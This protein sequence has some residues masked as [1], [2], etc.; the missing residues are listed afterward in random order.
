MDGRLQSLN[1]RIVREMDA[2]L[3][4]SIKSVI[5]VILGKVRTLT[6]GRLR[7]ELGLGLL[8]EG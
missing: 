7:E 2:I 5:K 1:Y 8:M 4:R 3:G 6:S